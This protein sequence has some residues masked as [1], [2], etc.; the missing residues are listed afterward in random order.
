MSHPESPPTASRPGRPP[1]S[2]SSQGVHSLPRAAQPAL[3]E[4]SFGRFGDHAR[5]SRSICARPELASCHQ[6]PLPKARAEQEPRAGPSTAREHP[7]S[8]TRV[9]LTNR[10]PDPLAI[11]GSMEPAWLTPEH[12]P[13]PAKGRGPGHRGLKGSVGPPC[14]GTEMARGEGACVHPVDSHAG[15]YTKTLPGPPCLLQDGQRP[16]R[17]PS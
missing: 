9:H 5:G 7:P 8:S 12:L 14:S 3:K 16:R 13:R 2:A 1:A 4:H 6:Q 17:A 10:A 11:S 15:R